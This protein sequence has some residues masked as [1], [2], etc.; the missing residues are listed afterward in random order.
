M[1]LEQLPLSVIRAL[2]GAS[3]IEGRPGMWWVN[4]AEL[5]E[6]KLFDPAIKELS[7][8]GNLARAPGGV[9]SVKG[10]SRA[11]AA[12]MT[13]GA[14]ET[15]RLAGNKLAPNPSARGVVYVAP[16]GHVRGA[17][18]FDIDKAAEYLTDP[19]DLDFAK[20]F[21]TYLDYVGRTS[22]ETSGRALLSAGQVKLGPE[23]VFQVAAPKENAAIYEAMGARRMAP[24]MDGTDPLGGGASLPA[25]ELR[26]PVKQLT[27]EERRQLQ[28]RLL[29]TKGG[30]QRFEG[31]RRGGLAQLR[32][33]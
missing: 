6:S 24:L 21:P 32:R 18:A 20:K 28:M 5:S 22:P 4:P 11:R 23:M 29:E 15:L 27:P 31:F 2:K 7:A 33:Q 16:S 14:L 13:Q 9:P 3:R 12:D 17:A 30:Q 26:K 10:K 25:F 8:E 1:G 19:M